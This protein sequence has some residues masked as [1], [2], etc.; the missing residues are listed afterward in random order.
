MTFPS[1]ASVNGCLHVE[2]PLDSLAPV[3][4]HLLEVRHLEG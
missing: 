3:N 2:D 1:V 4:A